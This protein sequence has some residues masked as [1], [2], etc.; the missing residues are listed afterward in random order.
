[1]SQARVL[2]Y[3][4]TLRDG[5]QAEDVA[6]TLED[7]LLIA[8]K[9]DGLGIHRIEGGWRHRLGQLHRWIRGH[10]RGGGQTI[11]PHEDTAKLLNRLAART[12]S[13]AADRS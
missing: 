7:K 3:D 12:G 10:G 13:P 2:L 8:E 5:T 4:T 1:M 6:L 11:E 9:L